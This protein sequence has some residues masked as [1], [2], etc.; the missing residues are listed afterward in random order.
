MGLSRNKVAVPEGAAGTP[1]FWRGRCGYPPVPEGMDGGDG[2]QTMG[3]A[4][5]RQTARYLPYLSSCTLLFL[6]F[7]ITR[8]REAGLPPGRLLHAS[9]IAQLVR[10][11]H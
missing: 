8:E 10:A 7:G 3:R 9:P 4:W 6:F 2:G 5:S 1:P 11:P